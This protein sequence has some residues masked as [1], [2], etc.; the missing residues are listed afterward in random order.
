MKKILL[1]C[2]GIASFLISSFAQ[3]KILGS[4][5][6]FP[7]NMSFKTSLPFSSIEVIDV[8]P[9]TTKIGYIKYQSGLFKKLITAEPLNVILK[10]HLNVQLEKY[11][12]SR[13]FENIF[14]VI[15]KLWIQQTDIDELEENKIS[16]SY[17]SVG[18]VIS[19][20]H[21]MFDI[22]LQ[23]DSLYI[24]IV[25]VDTVMFST[26]NLNKDADYLLS[27]TLKNCLEKINSISLNKI[28]SNKTL[29]WNKIEEY[30]NR[31]L[32]YPRFKDDILIKGIYIT[33][34]D[35]LNNTPLI[36]NF[37]TQSNELSDELYVEE[38][39]KLNLLE[40]FWGFCDGAKNYLHIGI[41]F[42][43][44][45]KVGNTYEIW[46]S[47]SITESSKRY[48]GRG[49][50]G[51]GVSAFDV[52]TGSSLFVPKT[53]RLYYKPLQLDIETGKLF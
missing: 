37:T 48:H 39:G 38:N 43:E 32:E 29:T 1:L 8:R 20:C 23:N 12:D 4:K 28:R 46:G 51:L 9:D 25:K 45:S 36:K 6:V 35:F 47:K 16:R 53:I 3:G 24:P 11:L 42:F 27:L 44:M 30:N 19:M 34:K 49:G 41:N 31:R 2:S 7:E 15:K 5:T 17:H 26:K 33:Y 52:L 10:Q 50:A 14:I 13:S 18:N 22:Y 40:N 21:S